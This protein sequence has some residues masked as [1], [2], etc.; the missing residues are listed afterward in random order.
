MPGTRKE[1]RIYLISLILLAVFAVCFVSAMGFLNYRTT[2]I[3]LEEQV[4]ARVEMDAVSGVETA[5]EF[6]KSFENYYGMDD[7]FRS[8]SEQY[9]SALPFVIDRE[10]N[11]LYCSD[12][13]ASESEESVRAFLASGEF[14][15]SLPVL[16]AMEGQVLASGSHHAIFANVEQGDDIV[17]FF[18]CLYQ[19][20]IFNESF[21]ALALRIG[22]MVILTAVIECLALLVAFKLLRGENWLRKLEVPVFRR[23][24]HSLTLLILTAGIVLLSAS[25]IVAYQRDY[26]ERTEDSVRVALQSLE[27]QIS[28]VSDQGVNLRE[29][30]GLKEYIDDHIRTLQM[31]R[32][33]RISSHI[34]EVLRTEE[35]SNLITFTFGEGREAKEQM[36]LEAEISDAAIAAEMRSIVLV[37]ISTGIILLIFVFELNRLVDLLAL[38]VHDPGGD[39]HV[40]EK[41]VSMALRFTGFLCSTAEYLCVP[42]AAMMIRA[43]GETLFGLSVGM[44][45]ALPLTLEGLVQMVGMLTLPRYVRKFNTRTVL[46]FSSLMMILCNLAAFSLRGALTV[47][48]C[49]GLA[50]FAYAGF[51]QVSNFLITRGYETELG[52][53]ENIA[54]DNAGLLAGATCGAGLGAILSANAGYAVTFLCSAVLFGLYLLLT[55]SVTPWKALSRRAEETADAAPVRPRE[56]AKMLFSRE[57][58]FFILTVGIPLNIGVMLCVTLIPA[59][60]QVTGISSVMLSYCYIANGLAGI[61][62]G[63]ML[64]A[65]AKKRF[66]IIPC[67]AFAFALTGVGIFILRIPPVAVMIV[68]TSMILGFLDGF[69]TPLTTDRFMSLRVVRTA[70]DES[71]ALIFSVVLSYVLLTFAPLVAELMLL[72]GRG[73]FSPMLLGAVLYVLVA[74]VLILFCNRKETK[75]G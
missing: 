54:Q 7:V 6:G 32:A 37:L 27:K 40:P 38:R 60:C 5:I 15:R 26:R 39:G 68:I 28:R 25:T 16:N 1:N 34:S 31:L 51:K 71:T 55:L 57:M 72:P 41:Q 11:L 45:A 30:S 18:G 24:E 70:V 74:V 52:R 62:I 53:S 56:L 75:N 2:A 22:R 67:I 8:L 33:V 3:D 29:V 64:V 21:R 14:R 36:F 10:G 73:D 43:S 48:I 35:E 20:S 42:Y 61:Y 12:G 69:A 13:R 44:T 9:P 66:G 19:D 49:R 23:I 58:I 50:G 17:G 46:I 63:P 4:I 65:R 47:V 59:I